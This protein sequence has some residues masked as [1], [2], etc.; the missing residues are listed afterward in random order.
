MNDYNIIDTNALYSSVD[1]FAAKWIAGHYMIV[2]SIL[3]LII[4]YILYMYISKAKA[5]YEGAADGT[6][7]TQPNPL[8]S[9]TPS[10]NNYA[11]E[12]TIATGNTSKSD[13]PGTVPNA[14]V[15]TPG[16]STY[17]CDADNTDYM[18]YEQQ[19]L[20][21]SQNSTSNAGEGFTDI[22][23]NYA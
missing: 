13:G 5:G 22:T 20:S 6:Q 9:A 3:V 15:I 11:L 2:F 10:I 16:Q 23:P 19:S 8:Y 4:I 21:N 1:N 14:D 18:G 7:V 17:S 12:S